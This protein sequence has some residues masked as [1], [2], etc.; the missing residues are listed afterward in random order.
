[1][2]NWGNTVQVDDPLL[3]GKKLKINL[4]VISNNVDSIVSNISTRGGLTI[5]LTR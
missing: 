4:I 3:G 1:M 5:I 2:S